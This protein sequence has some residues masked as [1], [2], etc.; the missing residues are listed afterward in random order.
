MSSLFVVALSGVCLHFVGIYRALSGF[1]VRFL[2][3]LYGSLGSSLS[4]GIS[5]LDV[6]LSGASA[7]R[8]SVFRRCCSRGYCLVR[9]SQELLAVVARVY[10]RSSMGAAL[11]GAGVGRL[12][13]FQCVLDTAYGVALSGAFRWWLSVRVSE[14]GPSQG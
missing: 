6:A 12:S 4:G 8:L 1:K 2:L 11:S 14:L 5:S 7:G 9:L 13:V 3:D 10:L